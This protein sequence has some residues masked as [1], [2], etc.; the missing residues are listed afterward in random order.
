M[1]IPRGI[2]ALSCLLTLAAGGPAGSARTTAADKTAKL[3]MKDP[4]NAAYNCTFPEKRV[5]LKNGRYEN[6]WE[7][8]AQG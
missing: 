8:S 4:G 1:T 2:T 6:N 5:T 3:T 7:D